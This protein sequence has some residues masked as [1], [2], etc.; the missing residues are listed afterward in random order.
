MPV[1]LGNAHNILRS[2]LSDEEIEQL[3]RLSEK[4]RDRALEVLGK[5]AE[6]LPDT[7]DITG[8]VPEFM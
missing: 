1:A 7:I 8:R 5:R 3:D 6:P 4:V 2:C